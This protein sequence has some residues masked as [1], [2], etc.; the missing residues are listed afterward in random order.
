[1]HCLEIIVARN[2]RAV[3]REECQQA[4]NV[5]QS[6]TRQCTDMVNSIQN[7]IAQSK[8]QSERALNESSS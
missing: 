3:S 8:R 5:Y 1:M 7:K 6:I 4:M 2:E